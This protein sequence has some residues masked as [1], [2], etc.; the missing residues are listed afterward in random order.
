MEKLCYLWERLCRSVVRGALVCLLLVSI[1][2]ATSN[3]TTHGQD[4]KTNASVPNNK[5]GSI[6]GRVTIDGKPAS[7]LDVVLQPRRYHLVD[8]PIATVSTDEEGRYQFSDVLPGHYWI[9]V[10]G[11]EYVTARGFEYDGPG[12]DVSIND[13]AVVDDGD[14]ALIRGG[15]VSGRILSS[16]GAGVSNEH[17]FLMALSGYGSGPM[18]LQDNDEKPFL[19]DSDGRYR[20]YGVPAGRYAIGVGVD[21]K[22][23]TGEVRDKNDFG[24]TGRVGADHY[25]AET[26]YPGIA[27]KSLAQLLEVTVGSE[28]SGINFTVG[29]RFRAYKVTGRVVNAETGEPIKSYIETGHNVNGGYHSSYAQNGPADTDSNGRFSIQG[30]LPG[31]FYVN[32]HFVEATGLYPTPVSFEIKDQDI[33]GLVIKAH[34]GVTISGTVSVA[35]TRITGDIESKISQL[36]LKASE[37]RGGTSSP[38]EREGVVGRDGSFKIVGL[39]P[40]NFELSLAYTDA[41]EYFSLLRV[42]YAADDKNVS[43][44]AGEFDEHAPVPLNKNGLEGLRVVLGYRNGRIK[45]HVE[46]ANGKLPVG[47]R[48]MAWITH[49]NSTSMP[50]LDSNGDY[51]KEGLPPGE[52]Q[53]QI[54][55]GSRRFTENKVVKIANNGEAR[56]SFV[57]DASKIEPRN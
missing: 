43:T 9:R 48:L 33:E 56:V 51:V 17:V 36:K 28:L 49:D 52:Y 39:R 34:R 10:S 32:A 45:I 47:V 55:D 31:S 27:D 8:K 29:T 6:S 41:S 54:G 42:E 7:R 18:Y 21:I 26:F 14:I 22:K 13:G 3:T 38:L 46:I 11:R 12:R 23:L 5:G 40:G 19:T 1:A 25:Y 30:L 35:G 2:D 15:V 44:A 53:I 37:T 16:D 57:V 50:E 4:P 24:T 20:I